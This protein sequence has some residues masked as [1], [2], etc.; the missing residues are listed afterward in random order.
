MSLFDS[1]KIIFQRV[2]VLGLGW[3]EPVTQ[4]LKEEWLSWCEQLHDLDRVA[5]PRYV[6]IT[7]VENFQVHVFSDASKDAYSACVYIKVGTVVRLLV[8]KAR[9]T[10]LKAQ[11]IPR[12][13][14]TAAMLASRLARKV[15]INLNKNLSEVVFW[16]DAIDVLWWLTRPAK[17]FKPYVSNRV[18][19]IQSITNPGQW[20]YCPTDL[21][22]ADI[23]TRGR[24]VGQFIE[25]SSWWS[26]PT[27][28]QGDEWPVNNWSQKDAKEATQ[29]LVVVTGPGERGETG[30]MEPTFPLHP[31]S[32][33]SWS[34]LVRRV[35][36]VRR[37]YLNCRKAVQDRA[38]GNNLEPVEFRGAELQLIK[39]C[40]LEAFPGDRDRL[41]RGETVT[42]KS[43]LLKLNPVIDSDGMLRS[44]SRLHAI[45]WLDSDFKYPLILPKDHAL[46]WLIVSGFHER[47]GHPLGTNATLNELN[48]RMWIIGARVVL[49]KV[50]FQCMK[51]KMD[52]A[53]SVQPLMGPVPEFRL[54]KPLHAFS[55]VSVDFAGPFLTK[56][57][58]GLARNKRYLALFTC[59]QTRAV[60]LELVQSLETSSFLNAL[61]RMVDRRGCPRTIVSD[62]GKTFV[63]ADKEIRAR[64][65]EDEAELSRR[66]KTITWRFLPPYAS[67]MG[68][69]HEAL[70]KS[71]KRALRCVLE[72]AD[73]DDDQLETAFVRVEALLNSRP[74]T[75]AGS[76][77]QDGLCLTP[78]HFLFGRVDPGNVL[79]EGQQREQ[80]SLSRRWKYVHTLIEHFWARWQKEVLHS[81]I[82]RNKWQRE[83]PSLRV[84]NVV[85]VLDPVT[86]SKK[87]WRLGKVV[88][89]FPGQDDQVR[90]VDVRVG[91]KVYRRPVRKLCMLEC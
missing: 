37:F 62:N 80:V 60:H 81:Y 13:E 66:H 4:S 2:W 77:V 57:G 8:A 25:D 70:V 67:N 48:K 58:R 14:L 91:G 40:Q 22:P 90:V 27:F 53:K 9:V 30:V 1:W 83:Q 18:G 38:A 69:V 16:V 43:K 84:G 73:I 15:C 50:Q 52:R 64:M 54:E 11:S 12:L 56:R 17:Q 86:S 82:T 26:G 6:G 28:L 45:A 24:Q 87:G 21:N 20:R 71:A 19:E 36:Y 29:A 68:G 79:S 88:K 76:S 23:P 34:R 3:D 85:M 63:K 42:R 61:S 74:L 7:R 47:L 46:T 59:L 49:K 32:W 65:L 10:P 44:K 41:S 72:Q 78:N 51:C 31:S 39:V 5:I 55:V 33:S 35:A 89:V 75:E